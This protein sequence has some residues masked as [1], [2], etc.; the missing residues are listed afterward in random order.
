[1]TY[2]IAN[3]K[4]NNSHADMQEWIAQ[5]TS[6]DLLTLNPN[7]TLIL[8]PPFP[9]LHMFQSAFSSYTYIAIGAQ[10][11][12]AFP[13]GAH[14]GDVPARSLSGLATYVLI[15]HSERRTLHNETVEM[16]EQKVTQTCE[17]GLTPILLVRGATDP[18]PHGVHMVAFEP[19]DAIGT[20]NNMSAQDVVAHMKELNLPTD[21]I[22]I[23]GGSVN[24]DNVTDY[25]SHD[26][27]DGVLLGKA[28]LDPHGLYN[29]LLKA[30]A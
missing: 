4:A 29:L 30:S 22:C 11:V 2:I 20:G 26:A 1:M 24:E 13:E 8:C 18:I 19:T 17:A 14:T 15:G 7:N 16:C 27:L 21:C 23:Y 10:D 12:S 9:F 28:S 3:F 25:L 5:F 6:H